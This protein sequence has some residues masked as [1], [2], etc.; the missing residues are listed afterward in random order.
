MVADWCSLLGGREQVHFLRH[1]HLTH[2]ERE[3]YEG[4]W[5]SEAKEMGQCMYH[6]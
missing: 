6:R 4:L 3:K 5:V 1:I 2:D